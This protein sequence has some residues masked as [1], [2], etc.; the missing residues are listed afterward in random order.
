MCVH[1]RM[2]TYMHTCMHIQNRGF[3]VVPSKGL[4]LK[5]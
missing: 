1:A 4:F 5:S 2:H 3:K